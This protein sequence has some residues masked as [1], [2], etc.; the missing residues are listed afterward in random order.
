VVY[1]DDITI[2]V[3]LAADFP[4]KEDA[5][6]RY[7]RASGARLNP[8]NSKALAVGSWS[9]SETVLGIAYHPHVKIL[10]VRFWDTSCN[11]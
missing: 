9:T 2:F 1:A 10:D 5:I 3:T 6:H 4:I 8:Q 7:E 11:Q